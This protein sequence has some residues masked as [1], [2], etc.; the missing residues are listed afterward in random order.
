M[1]PD[2]MIQTNNY[3]NCADLDAPELFI[4]MDFAWARSNIKEIMMSKGVEGFN[5]Q[6]GMFYIHEAN[7]RLL[8]AM[9]W[10]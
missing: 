5:I 2:G 9:R 3:S 7:D 8:F 1:K 4:I 10:P 6:S